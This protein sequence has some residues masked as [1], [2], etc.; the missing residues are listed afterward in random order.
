MPALLKNRLVFLHPVL[1]GAHQYL[2]DFAD[3]RPA[4]RNLDKFCPSLPTW[5]VLT[6]YDVVDYELQKKG[7]NEKAPELQAMQCK[8]RLESQRAGS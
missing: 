2:C 6:G 8:P 3:E 1:P 7:L 4:S 5:H